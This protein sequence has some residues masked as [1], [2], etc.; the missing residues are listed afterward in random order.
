MKDKNKQILYRGF[1][2]VAV[3]VG[4]VCFGRLG[5]MGKISPEVFVIFLFFIVLVLWSIAQWKVNHD[6]VK[7]Q[8][9]AVNLYQMYVQPLEGLVKE[10]RARQH[11]YDNH[12]HALVNMHLTVDNY[13]ELVEKQTEYIKETRKDGM[14]QYIPLLRISDKILA[15]FLYSKIINSAPWISTHLEIKNYEIIS[16]AL[17]PD[18]IEVAG[19]LV[20]NAYEACDERKKEVW[21]T[22]DSVEDQVLLEVRNEVEKVKIIDVEKFF[23]KGYSTKS[24]ERGFGLFRVRQLMEKTKGE[25]T[26]SVEEKDGI[27]LI[28]FLAKM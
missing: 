28:C 23:E 7:K 10:I 5:A 1:C 19:V 9:D 26:A 6:A 17:E 18:I 16:Q 14:K 4:T 8:K 3:L 22:L 24:K 27:E 11:E 12:I 25:L 13:E 20:D 2:I 15:G 21:I